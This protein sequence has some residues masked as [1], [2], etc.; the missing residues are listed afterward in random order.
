VGTYR[1]CDLIAIVIGLSAD[2][3][4]QMRICLDF[5]ESRNLLIDEQTPAADGRGNVLGKKA[6]CICTKC[7]IA[8]LGALE[9]LKQ[10][11][12]YPFEFLEISTK[13]AEGLDKLPVLF[14]RLLGII[15]IYAKPPGK[16]PDMADPFTLPTG[17]TVSDLATAIHRELADKLKFAK[18]WGTGV[19]QGQ[20]VQKNH[21]LSDRDIIE[22]HFA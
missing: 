5:L 1:N 2:V 10:S 19:Y 17:S 11:C 16:K 21:V 20:N 14:F 15:R 18:I 3:T 8:K 6:L 4:K 12:K 22:L 7:D 13:T 9:T